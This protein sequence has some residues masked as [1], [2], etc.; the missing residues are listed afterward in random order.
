MNI[1]RA[2]VAAT[3]I[4]A[5]LAFPALADQNDPRL[6]QLFARLKAAPDTEPL[7]RRGGIV[8]L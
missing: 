6:D 8:S 3:A 2:I 1:R 5:A 7:W 4:L